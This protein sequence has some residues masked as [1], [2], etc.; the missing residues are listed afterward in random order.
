MISILMPIYNG[1]EFIDESVSSIINQ[2]F[3]EWE[4][5]I[6]I[7]GHGLNSN[8]YQI[9]KKYENKEIKVIEYD[10]GGKSNTLNE[11]IKKVKYNW[12]AL[13]DVDDIWKPTKLEEQVKWMN[14]YDVIGTLTSYFGE[15]NGI[16]KLP[17]G[18]LKCFD[19][20][21]FNPITNSSVLL[22]KE[23]CWWDKDGLED[24]DLWL[25]LWKKGCKFY[26]VQKIL[27]LHRIH[28][29][30]AFNTNKS[31]KEKLIILKKKYS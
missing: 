8:I 29:T 25:K 28:K 6:G 14:E 12:V 9:A 13:L 16:P 1:I 20:L 19:F 22:K 7:N 17:Q 3:K 23:L 10:F 11:M 30:S 5:L 27:T 18:D 15:S 26:N 4:L 24:Y 31:L 2:T 21:K